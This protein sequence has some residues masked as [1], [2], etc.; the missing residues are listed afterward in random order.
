[1]RIYL[2]RHPRPL[3]ANGMC[4]GRRELSV[5]RDALATAC[6]SA[7]AQ[8]DGHALD[9]GR[10]FSSPA[11]RC[12][13]LARALIASGE[14]TIVSEL[15][16]MDFGSWEGLAWDAVPRAE[17]DAWAGDVWRYRPGGAE[18]A[19]L[20][21]ERWLSWATALRNSGAA[22]ALA[23]THAGLIRVALRCSGALSEAAFSQARIDFGSV[24]CIEFDAARI[25]A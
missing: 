20:V 25:S 12:V 24:H 23:V 11:T 7:R 16:E 19:A 3:A 21:A 17:L 4:Y 8:L 14:P 5:G 10:I 6:A 9:R 13:L 18:S 22:S 2:I 15:R 1:M